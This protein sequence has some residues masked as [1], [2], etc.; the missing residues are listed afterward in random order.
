MQG[1]RFNLK[2]VCFG[3]ITVSHVFFQK[4]SLFCAALPGKGK[5]KAV[6]IISL[7][8]RILPYSVINMKLWK[9]GGKHDS[10]L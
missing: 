8:K 2:V 10:Q 1:Q 4:D 7:I 6:E 5:G 9:S 3:L